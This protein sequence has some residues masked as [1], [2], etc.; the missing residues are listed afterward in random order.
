MKNNNNDL[1]N[2]FDVQANLNIKNIGIEIDEN[3]Y[4]KWDT[5]QC[6]FVIDS[7]YNY[8]K[9]NIDKFQNKIVNKILDTNNLGIS[10]C[11]KASELKKGDLAFL[12]LYKIQKVKLY[13]C[14]GIQFD[15]L[16]NCN[17]PIELLDYIENNRELVHK[18]VFDSLNS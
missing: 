7:T 11:D 9:E 15:L 5:T 8:I 1:Y 17:F 12:Y 10:C 2:R 16:E 13:N 6:D 4:L 14:L 18:K 3:L